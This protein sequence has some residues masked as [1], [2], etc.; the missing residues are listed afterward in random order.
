LIGRLERALRK[1][2]RKLRVDRRRSDIRYIIIDTKKQAIVET[3][4]DLEKLA[5]SAQRAQSV[6]APDLGRLRLVTTSR[7]SGKCTAVHLRLHSFRRCRLSGWT[8]L[9][10]GMLHHHGAFSVQAE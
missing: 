6:G 4:V 3:D 10:G 5:P 9:R 8:G 2:R 1:E 7:W